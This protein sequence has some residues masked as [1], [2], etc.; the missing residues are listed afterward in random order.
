MSSEIAK[1]GADATTPAPLTRP[2]ITT[3]A[4]GLR[5]ATERLDSVASVSL[6]VWF[7]AGARHET[8]AQNSVAHFLEHMAFKGTPTRTARRIAEEIE[9]VGGDLNA[10]TS[11]ETTAYHARVL[12]QDAACALDVLGDILRN[13]LFAADDLETERGVILQE[14]GQCLDTPDDV[15]FDWAQEVSFPDQPVGRPILGSAQNVSRFDADALRG[16]MQDVYAP[17]AMVVG[18][19]GAVSHDAIVRQA[20]ALFGD[21]PRRGAP[22]PA[23]TRFGGGEKRVQKDLE[24]AH[25]VLSFPAP[26]Y[27]DDAFFTAQI[28]SVLL[29]GGMS[30]RLFQEARELRGLCYSIFSQVSHYRDGGA[31]TIYAGT[32]GEQARELLEVTATELRRAAEAIEPREVDRARAQL[33]AGMLMGLEST[34]ARCERLARGLLSYGR[35]RPVEELI[36]R[37]EAVDAAGVRAMAEKVLATATPT[38][39]LYGPVADAPSYAEFCER[40]AA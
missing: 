4:N 23:P 25:I 34:S 10:Y 29:G 38:L 1:T 7:G 14:I 6:G 40:L 17:E 22:T 26:S 16:F 19:T 31:L 8:E 12:E 36:E 37:L 18:A 24:Q 13:P 28:Y 5:V 2:E 30:S 9:D 20:E 39:A 21:L 32:S 11:R 35:A 33:R 15:V 3:L 27:L